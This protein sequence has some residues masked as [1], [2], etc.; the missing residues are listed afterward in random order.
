MSVHPK[1]VVCGDTMVAGVTER[2]RQ[3][4]NDRA[5]L[6]AAL[7]A[8]LAVC[9]DTDETAVERVLAERVLARI[10]G[11]GRHQLYAPS[12]DRRSIEDLHE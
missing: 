3:L 6:I 8:L 4:E 9:P 12:I 7:L 2:L 11:D 1:I 5:R 10:N